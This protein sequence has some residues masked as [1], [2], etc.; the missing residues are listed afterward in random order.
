LIRIFHDDVRPAPEGWA[1]ARTNAEALALLR[2]NEVSAISLDYDLGATP[3]DGPMAK[4]SSPDGNG[5][6]L[7]E[8]MLAE[9]LV[10]PD[11]IIHSWNIPGA[12]R[13]EAAL[14]TRHPTCLAMR[15]PYD[16]DHLGW[17]L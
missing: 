16:P 4:G 12:R 3:E 1:L 15:C 13:M 5:Y 6:A 17:Y 10:P 11:V 14:M 7:V 2:S 8:A 9:G